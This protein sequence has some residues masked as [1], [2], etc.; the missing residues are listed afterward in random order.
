ME[1]LSIDIERHYLDK[2][3]QASQQRP[4]D[5]KIITIIYPAPAD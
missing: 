2:V 5:P 1:S 4:P 3:S